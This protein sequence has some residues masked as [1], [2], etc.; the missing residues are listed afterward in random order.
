MAENHIRALAEIV[1][2]Q[3]EL[4]R[5]LG[6]TT[7]VVSKW[8]LKGSAIREVGH[9][10]TPHNV[11]LFAWANANKVPHKQIAAHLDA[12]RC[13]VCGAPR[14]WTAKDAVRAAAKFR[15]RVGR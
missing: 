11:A 14:D 1:G 12:H 4:A 8:A 9:L 3:S 7:S 13:P 15:Y 6:V 10:P 5:I 2:S